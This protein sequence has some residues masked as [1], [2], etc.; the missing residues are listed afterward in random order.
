MYYKLVLMWILIFNIYA[1]LA[2]D[3]WYAHVRMFLVFVLYTLFSTGKKVNKKKNKTKW[4]N[5]KY[6]R[7]VMISYSKANDFHENM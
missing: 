1:L 6:V 7:A 2:F 5:E 4:T 3:V